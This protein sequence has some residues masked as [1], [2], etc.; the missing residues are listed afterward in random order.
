M[1][2]GPQMVSDC[3]SFS[4]VPSLKT[5]AVMRMMRP[6]RQHY[7]RCDEGRSRAAGSAP[8]ESE[9]CA[10]GLRA[11]PDTP[12][13]SPDAR[14][15]IPD[16]ACPSADATCTPPDAV[17][18][19]P[20]ARCA[21]PDAPGRSPDATGRSAE[22]VGRP[23]KRFCPVGKLFEQADLKVCTTTDDCRTDD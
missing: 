3:S 18:T 19:V 10:D 6:W 16:T 11:S 7:I 23:G 21:F 20:D 1:S 4:R 17:C 9:T 13:A 5:S 12:D 2:P 15:S 22:R 14:C 8:D